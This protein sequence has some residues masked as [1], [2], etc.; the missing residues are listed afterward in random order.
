MSN[1]SIYKNR[2]G[3]KPIG[4]TTVDDYLDNILNGEY[5]DIVL[6]VRNGKAQKDEAEAV[7]VSATFESNRRASE[8]SSHSGFI[9]I[10][11]DQADN[12]DLSAM[13]SQLQSDP[14][15]YACHH[16]IRG[17]GLVWYVKI[18]SSKHK[19]AFRAIEQYLANT[20]NVTVDPSGKDV[21][22]LRFI[23]Y[24][25]DLYKNKSSK[26]WTRYIPKKER[27]KLTPSLNVFHDDDM[28]HIIDQVKT[29]I[30]IAEDYD[31]WVKIAFAL[32]KH[33]GETGRD[34]FHVVSSQSS[35][36]DPKKCDRQYDTSLRRSDSN[37]GIDIGTFF[38][39]CKQAGIAIKTQ[40][41]NDIESF[42]KIQIKQGLSK[43][44]AFER[45]R[46]YF[47]L[48][49][50]LS[51]DRVNPILEAIN[52]IPDERIKREKSDDKT[53]EMELFIKGY[54]LRFNEV[55]RKIE[56][57]D[58][59]ITDR[60]TNTIYMRAMHSIDHNVSKSKIMDMMDSDIV[61]S[62]HPFKEFFRKNINKKPSGVI[63]ELIDCFEY[64]EPD[65]DMDDLS[66]SHKESDYLSVF[67]ERWLLGV[68]SAMNGTYSLLVLVL[69]GGQ[70]TGKSNFF[71]GLL[72]AELK[73]YYAES[74]LD[75]DKD[76]GILMTQKL[77][78][79]D[80]EFSGKSKREAAKFKEISSRDM[81]TVR[82]PY[83]R[84]FEDLKRY[85][86]LCGTSNEDDILNDLTGNRRLIP[87]RIKSF[88]QKKFDGIDKVDLF[89]ELYHKWLD[90][91]DGW[92]LTKDDILF[93]NKSTA[94]SEMVNM[95]KE[96]VSKLYTPAN[97]GDRGAKFIQVSD[98]ILL[99]D[100]VYSVKSYP[101]KM[102]V[103]LK[104]LGFDKVRRSI[105]GKQHYG[106]WAIEFPRN[107]TF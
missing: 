70:G 41:S 20:Y 99:M 67:M 101:A 82:K 42:A 35:K 98:V 83:G 53:T 36:Y 102:G 69:T 84:S 72:P 74:K 80:D 68:I 76:D 10:D 43:P 55:S 97:A 107:T 56:K 79:M 86:V 89:L 77:I 88:N 47:A 16:S 48:Q 66:G 57:D 18:D 78:L 44:D 11:L 40:V 61:P 90:V 58:E 22:R 24:D 15:C 94:S 75:K 92:M 31:S 28:K 51:K 9:G 49:D 33:F 13:R 23:S 27:P 93:L 3:T 87:V 95:D 25:P 38:W 6:K 14:Y 73:P 103:L 8:M 29:G 45:T 104:S 34:Y 19:E 85:A 91:K 71:R 37:G 12:E 30:N 96:I 60:D 4:M 5:Q 65:V 64:Y 50:G 63:K 81:F 59:P 21:S 17:F 106:Y 7:T 32:S 105:K 54:G 62:Y 2:F 46:E 1:I 39:Y 52:N 100:S 26:K